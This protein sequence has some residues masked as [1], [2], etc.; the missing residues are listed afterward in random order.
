MARSRTSRQPNGIYESRRPLL[1]PA[2]EE[3]E[4]TVERTET[5]RYGSINGVGHLPNGDDESGPRVEV[6]GVGDRN[7]WRD[8]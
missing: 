2:E 8:E 5:G 6:S 3:E 1:P 4:E 7:A